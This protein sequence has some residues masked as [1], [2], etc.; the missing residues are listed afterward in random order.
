MIP[1]NYKLHLL[2]RKAMIKRIIILF[3]FLAYSLT[4][5]HSLIPHRHD[6]ER[7]QAQN[8]HHH[9]HD[10]DDH[11]E[12]EKTDLSHFF[13]DVVHHPSAE[14]VIH[15]SQSENVQKTKALDNF[16]ALVFDKVLLLDFKPP[17]R[18]F[19]DQDVHYSLDL[20]GNSH[21]RAPPAI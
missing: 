15:S 1:L 6:D 7:S 3:T 13:S 16:V 12:H 18:H 5:V 4:L 9:G 10:E 2:P 17:D 8:E 19:T 20:I 14:Q 11:H 21:M